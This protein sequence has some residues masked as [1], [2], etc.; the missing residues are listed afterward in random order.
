[1]NSIPNPMNPE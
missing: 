1:V